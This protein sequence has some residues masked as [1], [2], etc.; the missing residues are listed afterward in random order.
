MKQFLL[1]LALVTVLAAC[2]NQGSSTQMA[3]PSTTWKSGMI[4]D[5]TSGNTIYETWVFHSSLNQVII[6]RR[7]F[8]D[9]LVDTTTYTYTLDG[10]AFILNGSQRVS[11]TKVSDNQNFIVDSYGGRNYAK[12]MHFG[13]QF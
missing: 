13:R 9:T 6:T 10:D 12:P 5:L 8:N 1:G 11:Y 7:L 2:G 3:F 4:G